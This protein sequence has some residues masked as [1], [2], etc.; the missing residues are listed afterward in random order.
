M[1]N[2]CLGTDPG[3]R[4]SSRF[5]QLW[6]TRLLRVESDSG[7]SALRETA[8]EE[9]GSLLAGQIQLGIHPHLERG[10]ERME[11]TCRGHYQ[12]HH[13]HTHS[14]SAGMLTLVEHFDHYQR[15]A[16]ML[17]GSPGR[18]LVAAAVPGLEDSGVFR[19]RRHARHQQHQD[20][21]HL[22]PGCLALGWQMKLG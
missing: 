2:V 14:C 18:K 7:D 13:P 9:T 10:L 1:I 22:V 21:F 3:M 6:V 16:K 8:G 12:I 4:Y 20:Q 17:D 19:L 5:V 11:R 15:A